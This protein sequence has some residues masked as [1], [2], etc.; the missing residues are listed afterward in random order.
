[1]GA[2]RTPGADG[3]RLVPGQE[4][5][6]YALDNTEHF[7]FTD[8]APLAKQRDLPVQDLDG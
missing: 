6:E 1:V 7:S 3:L 5:L 4:A 2:G 8:V